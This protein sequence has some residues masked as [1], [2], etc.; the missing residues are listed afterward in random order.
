MVPPDLLADLLRKYFFLGG[1]VGPDDAGDKE[2][3][4]TRDVR[5]IDSENAE[6][7]LSGIFIL[8]NI[9]SPGFTVEPV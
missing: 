8:T 5:I 9:P 4:I 6:A 3:N 1:N 2:F 7:V